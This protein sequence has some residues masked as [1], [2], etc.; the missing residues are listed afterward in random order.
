ML[1]AIE[2]HRLH[3]CIDIVWRPT[4]THRLTNIGWLGEGEEKETKLE[5]RAIRLYG[6]F[7]F[8]VLNPI[9]RSCFHLCPTELFHD[10]ATVTV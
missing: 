9:A 5:Q 6:S 4:K 8:S 10:L 2:I 1:S 7:Q 3:K